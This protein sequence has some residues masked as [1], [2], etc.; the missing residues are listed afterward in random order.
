MLD[1][2]VY[3]SIFNNSPV[4]EYLLS[5][6]PEATILAVN[7]TF[8]RAVSRKREELVGKGLFEVFPE[9]PDDP[10]DTGV[11]ALH[12]SLDKVIATGRADIMPLQRYPIA[13]KL[14]DGTE[15]YE[16]RFWSASNTPIFDAEGRLVCISH[17]TADVTE[18]K[19][20]EDEARQQ[21]AR[22]AFQLALA[23]R[24]R[25]LA[26]PEEVTA[27]AC[28]L[29]GE[30]LKVARVVYAEIDE[31]NRTFTMKRDW[32]DGKLASVSGLRLSLDDFG[33]LIVDVLRSGKT[34]SIADI[35]TDARSAPYADAYAAN[36]VRSVL[37]MP[38]MKEGKLRAT[39]N[40]HDSKVHHWTDNEIAL[41]AD[42]V[43]RTW[44][45]MERAYAE[46]ER[47]R[48][49]EALRQSDRRKDEFLAML[50]HELR[51]PLAPIGAAAELLQEVKLGE[52]RVRQTSQ[53]IGRQVSHM[54]HLIDDLLDVS[55][56]TR[57]LVEL[58]NAP[59]DIRHVVTDAVEQVTPLIQSRRH[60]LA[61]LLPPDT[62]MV[63]GDKK[64]L[65]QVVT[66]IVANAAKYTDEC[67]H[68]LLKTD[69]RESHVHIEVIDNGVGMTSD[70][71]AR[72][73][74][75][76]AQAERSSD[77]SLGGLGLGLA[78][79]KSLVELH[80]G[81]VACESDGIGKGSKFTVCLPRLMVRD[82]P[83]EHSC[84]DSCV[85]QSMK[86]L[87]IM[88]VD[89]NA[90]AGTMLGMLLE[91][92]GHR[93]LV[94][95]GARRALMRAKA[96]APDVCLLDIGL[97]EMDGNELAQ[98]LRA[99]PETANSMLIAVTGYG[100]ERDRRQSLQAGFDHHLV[101][102]VDTKKLVSILAEISGAGLSPGE[103]GL[104]PSD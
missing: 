32:T 35:T 42:M 54:T 30:Q 51:N 83:D 71:A 76:F 21:A 75:L 41:A 2:S 53:I 43:D 98:R 57:G 92:S 58:D 73:F 50:A 62:T 84:S 44:S 10:E 15:R 102:P 46:E 95:H 103:A 97:P 61:L 20:A 87:C 24:I 25:P 94:E 31:K 67:G 63:M 72:A 13:V 77:R 37:A 33:P 64:R 8:L 49:E 69:V 89:D 88:I 12:R 82:R 22:Q 38:L 26:V 19:R 47:V 55:R 70:L 5:P 78:L 27:T 101:K 59:L 68:I 17:R 86:P 100:Q 96:E 91:A 74:D 45:A 23:D 1:H 29:L 28:E 3:E 79:V 66:N 18:R 4:G 93:V 60:H 7:D 34:L 90:D 39:L 11:T 40:I 81:M 99:Q 80:G 14:A 48:A 104:D 6:T 85:R 36:G 65:V 9:N 16:E 56:V 52:E